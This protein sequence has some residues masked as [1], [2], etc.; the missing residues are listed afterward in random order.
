MGM[1]PENPDN[2]YVHIYSIIV[3]QME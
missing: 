1:T 3:P 2:N